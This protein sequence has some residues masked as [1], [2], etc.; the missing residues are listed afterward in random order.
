VT[1][2]TIRTALELDSGMDAY[3]DEFID[4]VLIP[5]VGLPFPAQQ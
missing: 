4:R 2:Q 1:E 5:A 3:L